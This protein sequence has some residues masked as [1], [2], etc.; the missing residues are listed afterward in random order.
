MEDK[1]SF[2]PAE[3]AEIVA[4]A[5][6]QTNI[7]WAAAVK[8]VVVDNKTC[9]QIALLT[10]RNNMSMFLSSVAEEI[11]VQD[12]TEKMETELKEILDDES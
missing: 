9:S 10:V 5:I 12:A 2:T 3:V 8:E 7:A 11:E 6:E 4:G 1:G